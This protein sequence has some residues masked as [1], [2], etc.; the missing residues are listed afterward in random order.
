MSSPPPLLGP[1]VLRHLRTSLL[2]TSFHYPRSWS[3]TSG[4]RSTNLNPSGSP[5]EFDK[6]KYGL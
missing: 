2:R 4:L 6:E 5:P 3:T 1:S